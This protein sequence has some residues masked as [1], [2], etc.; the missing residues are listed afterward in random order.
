MI[1]MGGMTQKGAVKSTGSTW[2]EEAHLT[3]ERIKACLITGW[4]QGIPT[5]LSPARAILW[6]RCLDPEVWL[7]MAASSLL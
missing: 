6:I 1:L 2:R 4:I 3:C 5:K 7:L